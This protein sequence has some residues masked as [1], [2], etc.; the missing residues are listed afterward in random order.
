MRMS[1]SPARPRRAAFLVA[2]GI[3][4]SRIAGL[5]RQRVFAYYFGLTAPADAFMM[6][7]SS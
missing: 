6:S 7:K 1:T 4:S 2:V 3:L 5:I